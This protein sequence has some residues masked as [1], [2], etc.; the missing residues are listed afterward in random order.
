MGPQAQF[1]CQSP[2]CRRQAKIAI[3][4]G[5]E[6]GKIS[7]PRCTCGWEMKRVYFKP[8]FQKLSKAEAMM[9]LRD[10]GFS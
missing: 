8:V 10:S 5:S 3:S 6:G 9:R 7:N 2:V 4:T 1:V